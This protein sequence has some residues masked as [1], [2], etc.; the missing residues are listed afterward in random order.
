MP[1]EITTTRRTAHEIFEKVLENASD[2]LKRSSRALAFSGVAGGMGMG[3]T[4][5]SVAVAQSL[6]GD[7]GWQQ[8]AALLFYPLGFVAVIIGRAQLF[9]E[10]TLFPVALILTERRHVVNTLRL[11]T[12]VFLANLGGAML[13][14]LVTMKTGALPYDVGIRLAALGIRS[15][16]G[17]SGH[18]FWSAVIGGWIIALMAWTVTASHWTIGQVAVVWMLTVVVGMGRFAHCIATSGEILSAVFTSQVAFG[19]YG[20]WLLF[21]T[22]GNVLGGVTFVT[23]LNFGQ[24]KLED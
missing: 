15:V 22:L 18:I 16:A 23:L 3:L 1:D 12:V 6:L 11:W 9:T 19:T 5:L 13:F 4:G 14:A 7:G 8:F 17:S 2:E 24:V 21:A 20:H 10:N